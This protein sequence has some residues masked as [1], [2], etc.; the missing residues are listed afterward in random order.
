LSDDRYNKGITTRRSVLGDPHVDRM[1]GQPDDID[2]DFQRYIT[3]NAW[4]D[5]WNRPGLSHRDRSLLT[6]VMLASLGHHEELALHI[7][8]SRNTGTT[9]DEVKEALMQVAIYAGVPA[10]NSAFKVAKEVFETE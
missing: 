1:T 6:I 4:G 8:A 5:I 10:A 9:T 2:A 7:R 3:Q